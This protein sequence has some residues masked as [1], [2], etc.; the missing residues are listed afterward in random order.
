MNVHKRCMKMVPSNC[1]RDHTEK[2]G[3]IRLDIKSD[4]SKIVVKGLL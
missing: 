3:R 2:R 4:A 1:G